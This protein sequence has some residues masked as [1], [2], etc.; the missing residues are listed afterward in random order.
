MAG[1]I[2]RK[3]RVTLGSDNVLANQNYV[4]KNLKE[5]R[6]LSVKIFLQV[7]F[8]RK[9]KLHDGAKRFHPHF[10]S[11]QTPVCPVLYVYQY[12]T[13]SLSHKP[14]SP[15]LMGLQV[16]SSH[17]NNLSARQPA[18]NC[19]C[20]IQTKKCFIYNG[21]RFKSSVCYGV[22]RHIDHRATVGHLYCREF[23]R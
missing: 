12:I 23:N 16:S 13:G 10:N 7:H 1:M 19:R 8:I 15:T 2:V 9:I 6:A 3:G 5:V 17:G 18:N 4:S 20:N 21:Q 14:S 22:I 11:I